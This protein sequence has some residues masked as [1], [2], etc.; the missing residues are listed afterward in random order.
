[1]VQGHKSALQIFP[2]A[3]LMAQRKHSILGETETKAEA[4]L[5]GPETFDLQLHFQWVLYCTPYRAVPV[6]CF[7]LMLPTTKQGKDVTC[8][9]K[10]PPALEE[11][12]PYSGKNNATGSIRVA[13]IVPVTLHEKTIPVFLPP[14]SEI[15]TNSPEDKVSGW[16][17]QQIC[18][19]PQAIC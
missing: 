17:I 8:F 2:P 12:V 15:N 4:S 13:H 7:I 3:S 18:R 11:Q 6:S 5:E 16:L 1:M 14:I 9:C 19:I 10:H